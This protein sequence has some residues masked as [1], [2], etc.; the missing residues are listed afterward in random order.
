MGARFRSFIKRNFP[1]AA[2]KVFNI[3]ASLKYQNKDAR[4]VFQSIYNN[5]SWEGVDSVSGAG[6]DLKQTEEISRYLPQVISE[7]NIQ[8]MLDIPCGDHFWMNKLNL[9]IKYIGAD[10][11]S[12]LID[13]NKTQYKEDNKSFICLDI[14]KDTLPDIDLVF[15]RDCFIHFSYDDIFSAIDN[16]KKSG[17]KYLM[18]TTFPEKENR[19][20]ATGGWRMLNLEAAPFNLPKPLVCINEKCDEGEAYKTKSMALWEISR[21]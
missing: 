7:Y 21:L 11:V 15:C 6:S 8:S 18:T 16:I 20:I 9:D 10:I 4:Q 2:T 13:K 17:A 14:I 5:N 12:A 1:A 19:D 3:Y